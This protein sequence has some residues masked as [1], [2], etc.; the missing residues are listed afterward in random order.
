MPRYRMTL[1]HHVRRESTR[2]L[3]KCSLEFT[4]L[5]VNTDFLRDLNSGPSKSQA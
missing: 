2:Q 1:L 4:W 3:Q 5:E